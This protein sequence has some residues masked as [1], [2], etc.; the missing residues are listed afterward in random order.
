[1]NTE[2]NQPDA[3]ALNESGEWPAEA[4]A[5]GPSAS[6]V[7][8]LL[9]G[10]YL[11]E[12]RLGRGG[13]GVVYLARDQQLMSKPVVVK[14]MLEELEGTTH[15][16]WFKLK[17][18][19]EIEALARID[20][21]GVV[22]VLDAGEMPDG[23]PWLVTQFIEGGSLG[24]LMQSGPL[25]L[26]RV[27]DLMRQ[28]GH[29]LSAAHDKGV[30]HRD[31]KPENIMIQRLAEGE[32]LARLIDFG[33]AT[34]KDSQLAASRQVTQAAG[35]LPYMAPEQ[36][37]GRPIAASD[38]YALGVM[39][40]EMLTG[41]PPF[42]PESAVHL[43]ELQRAGV[44]ARPSELRPDLPLE[45]EAIILRA[46]AWDPEHRFSSAR[47]FGD[48]LARALLS[49]PV[50]RKA[51]ARQAETE[52]VALAATMP[53]AGAQTGSSASALPT[54]EIAHV[55][56]VRIVRYSALPLDQQARALQ[57]LQQI[58]RD[59]PEYRQVNSQNQLISLPASDGLAL[60]F[61]RSAVSPVRCAL[62]IA[63]AAGS[64]LKLKMGIHSGPVHRLAD[65]NAH[66]MVTG[67]GVAVAQQLAD[68]GEEGHILVSGAVA[69]VLSQLSN[70]EARLHELGEMVLPSGM[71]IQ[72]YN[73]CDGTLG[74]PQRPASLGA[75]SPFTTQPGEPVTGRSSKLKWYLAAA[76][77]LLLVIF[78]LAFAPKVMNW[79]RAG[80]APSTA[81]VQ[82][83]RT[84]TYWVLVERYRGE[85]LN[86][87]LR[88]PQEVLLGAKDQ[89]R[90]GIASPQ[91]GFLYVV[92]EGPEKN[93]GLP[94]YNLLFPDPQS[95]RGLAQLESGQRQLIPETSVFELDSRKGTETI[96][97]IW[98]AQRLPLMESGSVRGAINPTDKGEIKD[99]AAIRAI[100]NLL[101]TAAR[102][103]RR[104][105]EE[106]KQTTISTNGDLLVQRV[107]FEHS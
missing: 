17:F 95:N 8:M 27:A 14:V 105:D 58:V 49:K 37:R 42:N 107:L 96:W 23:R 79:I 48:D 80:K 70:Q 98:S 11:I 90:L 6:Y 66:R 40:Y 35:T 55:L 15:Q 22:G 39:A 61:F 77:V 82:S 16:E 20:H 62:E 57:Q 44:Q 74:N 59:A 1:M 43:A 93:E 89:V 81:P 47:I 28:I 99:K 67:G 10:R 29:A 12:R 30:F 91:S 41:Q 53:D 2:P 50:A 60:V 63:R 102:P 69:D 25:S 52:L 94:R 24:T 56:Y 88:F 51:G 72:L 32:E 71:K 100:E 73:L 26:E 18:R 19:Q 86:E 21:P 4:E 7:G 13:V 65:I 87:P 92:G 78:G 103:E 101:R 97:L 31:I 68:L 104:V 76:P 3:T 34:V 85:K 5:R 45:A 36:L 106:K 33:I 64:Q 46:L 83:S 75:P 9:K 84:L 54:V 38:I